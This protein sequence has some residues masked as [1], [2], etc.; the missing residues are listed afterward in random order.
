MLKCDWLR[1]GTGTVDLRKYMFGWKNN[2]VNPLLSG[3]STQNQIIAISEGNVHHYKNKWVLKWSTP[4]GCCI[5]AKQH[6]WT[7][8]TQQTPTSTVNTR[9]DNIDHERHPQENRAFWLPSNMET[10]VEHQSLEAQGTCVSIHKQ[11]SAGDWKQHQRPKAPATGRQS[12]HCTKLQQTNSSIVWIRHW[13]K[14]NSDPLL[15]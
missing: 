9:Q 15:Q 4:T 1:F 2:R 8:Y 11:S 7:S 6:K 14:K 5:N 10:P 13:W 3:Q 12:C